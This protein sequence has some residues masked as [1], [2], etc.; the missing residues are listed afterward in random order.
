MSYVTYA[1]IESLVDSK[2]PKEGTVIVYFKCPKTGHVEE[3]RGVISQSVGNKLANEATQ[4]GIR[5]LTATVSRIIRQLTGVH[6]PI[7]NSASSTSLNSGRAFNSEEAI[8]E[9]VINAFEKVSVYPGKPIKN[10]CFNK[11]PEEGWV[12][13]S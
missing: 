10:G 8:R 1:E 2:Q 5:F 13:V 3:A 12:F 6:L 9:G 7:G 11:L 4:G